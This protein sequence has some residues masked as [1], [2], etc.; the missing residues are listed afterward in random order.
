MFNKDSEAILILLS[1]E[2]TDLYLGWAVYR[3][4]IS[5]PW[6]DHF[7]RD[8]AVPVDIVS[9][10]WVSV[11]NTQTRKADFDYRQHPRVPA[12]VINSCN[13]TERRFRIV[14]HDAI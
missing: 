9:S 6:R 4:E 5:L 11:I 7:S 8:T 12:N 2:A 3:L 1:T 13:F 14:T 10:F